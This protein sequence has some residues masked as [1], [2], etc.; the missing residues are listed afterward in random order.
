MGLHPATPRQTWEL[1]NDHICGL[2]LGHQYHHA[3]PSLR[4]TRTALCPHLH[5][6]VDRQLPDRQAAACEAGQ[7]HI[8]NSHHQHWRS[9]GLCSLPT[10]LLP[11]H[12]WL[13]FKEPLCQAPEVCGLHYSHRPHQ[14]WRRVCLQTGGWA[15]GCLVQSKQP[16]AKHSLKTVEMIVDFRRNPPALPPLAIMNS[17]VA[18]VELFRFLGTTSLKTW[19]GT[20]TMTLSWKK[21]QQRLYLLLS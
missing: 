19:S 11:L 17:T 13:R 9:S 3:W 14:G 10:A 2:Q 6:S 15:A 18:A 16:G 7:T 4:Q 20:I 1:R 21:A 12:Q 8:Q 5:L